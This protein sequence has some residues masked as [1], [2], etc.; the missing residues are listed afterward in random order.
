MGWCRPD[1]SVLG[2]GQMESSRECGY[3]PS[4]SIKC[5]ETINW[6]HNWWALEI[7]SSVELVT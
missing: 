5:W 1:W 7:L 6:L 3:E 2:Q 4:G